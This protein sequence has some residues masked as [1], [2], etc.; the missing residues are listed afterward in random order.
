MTAMAEP[1]GV[2]EL[3]SIAQGALIAHDVRG[4]QAALDQLPSSTDDDPLVGY[5]RA[6]ALFAARMLRG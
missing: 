4:A 3:L 6:A 2:E 5:I 1:A